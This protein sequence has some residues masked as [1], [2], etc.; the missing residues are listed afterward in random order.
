L[1]VLG[2]RIRL[3]NEPFFA[4]ALAFAL[5]FP[6]LTHLTRRCTARFRAVLRPMSNP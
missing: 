3:I 6:T 4:G 5:S 1:A 2:L